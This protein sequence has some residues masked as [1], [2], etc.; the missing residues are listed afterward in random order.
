MQELRCRV[1]EANLADLPQHSQVHLRGLAA[2]FA[3]RPPA[4]G[5]SVHP[6]CGGQRGLHWPERDPTTTNHQG[7]FRGGI[8]CKRKRVR[9]R[10]CVVQEDDK[11]ERC[12]LLGEL[13]KRTANAPQ[14]HRAP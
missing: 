11:Q 6:C 13:P 9:H 3:R 10:V 14:A 12:C 1:P 7:R 2:L 5:T 8:G 4:H